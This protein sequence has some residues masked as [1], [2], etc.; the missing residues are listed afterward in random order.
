[1]LVE[2]H[3]FRVHLQ[4]TAPYMY[5]WNVSLISTYYVI[6]ND[7]GY[8]INVRGE[9]IAHDCVNWN[10]IFLEELLEVAID[11]CN[12]VPVIVSF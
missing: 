7:S 2:N 5:S 12:L 9:F 8:M 6:T 11:M 4:D 3:L 10:I 1:M